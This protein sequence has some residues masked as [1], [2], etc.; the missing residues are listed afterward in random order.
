MKL[1]TNKTVKLSE[2][3]AKKLLTR[4]VEKKAGKKVTNVEFSTE[5]GFLFFLEEEESDLADNKEA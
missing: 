3:E 2:E 5:S 1:I 4:F